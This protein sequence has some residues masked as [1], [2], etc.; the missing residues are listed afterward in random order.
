VTVVGSSSQL[1]QAAKSMHATVNLSGYGIGTY[2]LQPVVQVPHG[3]QVQG[4]SP[5]TVTV[6]LQSTTAG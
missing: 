4:V 5:S 1:A 6:T 2:Q 3:M